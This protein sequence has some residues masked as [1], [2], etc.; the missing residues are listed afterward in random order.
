MAELLHC[1]PSADRGVSVRALWQLVINEIKDSAAM[2]MQA[3]KLLA[4]YLGGRVAAE[5]AVATVGDWLAD[6]AC[7]RNPHVLLVAGLIYA[8]VCLSLH[9][10][11]ASHQ[12]NLLC[13]GLLLRSMFSCLCMLQCASINSAVTTLLVLMIAGGQLCGGAQGM[14]FRPYLGNVR[15]RVASMCPS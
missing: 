10:L 8:Q 14:P 13:T 4:K 5:E 7:N 1:T 2:A 3:I 12:S 11:A 9:I 15:G 6:I